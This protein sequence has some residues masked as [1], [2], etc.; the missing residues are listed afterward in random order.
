LRSKFVNITFFENYCKQVFG[1]PLWPNTD[2]I[3]NEFGGKYI[4][5][6]NTL[7]VNGGE[8]PWLWASNL[9]IGATNPLDTSYT[10]NCNNCGHCIDLKQPTVNDP[11][12]LTNVRVKILN[13]ITNW[14]N[15]PRSSPVMLDI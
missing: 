4:A 14:F 13:N 12:A 11:V 3:N 6:S 10:A 2:L 1:A 8:D 7:I 5:S 9:N 15:A